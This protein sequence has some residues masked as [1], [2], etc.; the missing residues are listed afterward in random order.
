MI[1]IRK[2]IAQSARSETNMLKGPTTK[3]AYIQGYSR[4]Q[5]W[6]ININN[7][8]VSLKL[9]PSSSTPSSALHFHLQTSCHTLLT[10]TSNAIIT[11][12]MP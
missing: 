12:L 10:Q 11:L 8:K 5:S 9:T 2:Q 6:Y 3:G 7:A 4:F 1:Q